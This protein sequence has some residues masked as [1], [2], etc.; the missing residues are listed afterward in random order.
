MSSPS[1]NS[2]LEKCPSSEIIGSLDL[3]SVLSS[4]KTQKGKIID[5]SLQ[6]LDNVRKFLL[7][8]E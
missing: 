6:E 5:M 1:Y 3:N 2:Y 8:Y 7:N 4:P